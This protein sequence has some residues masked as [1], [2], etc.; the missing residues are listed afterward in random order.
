MKK[1]AE[2][3]LTVL[4]VLLLLAAVAS[5]KNGKLFGIDN[6]KLFAP[7]TDSVTYALPSN[8]VLS[9][10]AQPFEKQDN[11]IWKNKEDVTLV[12]SGSHGQSITGYA[13][14]TPVYIFIKDDRIVEVVPDKN[15][16]TPSFFEEV[17][18]GG[19]LDAWKGVHIDSVG[20]TSVDAVSGATM[21]S[22]SLT[23][24][25]KATIAAVHGDVEAAGVVDTSAIFS[26]KTLAALLVLIAGVV[27]A[28]VTKKKKWRNVQLVLNLAVLGFWCGQFISLS[29]IVGWFS[30]GFNILFAIIPFTM[31]VLAVVM[32]LIGKK[33]YYC[34][35]VCPYGAAQELV[36][37][38]PVKKVRLT[39]Q[40]TKVLKY[41]R[42]AILYTIFVFAWLGISTNLIDYEPFSAFIFNQADSIVIAIAVVFLILSIFVDKAWCRF[43][44]PTGL[45][46]GW[47]QISRSSSKKIIKN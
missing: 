47:T 18:D 6:N 36:G 19:V 5:S 43:A 42:E 17:I 39:P 25:V 32:P 12:Y 41:A 15:G 29:L 30:S 31:V 21:S 4:I 27:I 28:F 38:L 26:I 14:Q 40:V 35:W 8:E 2:N 20:Y 9:K 23:R 46:L 7:T 16:E 11:S 13:G 3:L 45:I 33:S 10:Y 44:C 24:T 22:N 34:T 1:I 37:K